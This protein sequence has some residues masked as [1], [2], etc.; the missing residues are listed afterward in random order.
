M[1][2]FGLM[3]HGMTYADEAYSDETRDA[4]TARFWYPRMINGEIIFPRPEQ[5][6]VTKKIHEMR[7]K[8]FGYDLDNFT[9]LTEFEEAEL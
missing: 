5:C 8:P 2:T 7:V 4:M 6:T 1:L 9:G 3:F